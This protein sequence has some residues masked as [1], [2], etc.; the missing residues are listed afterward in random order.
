MYKVLQLKFI[1]SI[2]EIKNNLSSVLNPEY[3][4]LHNNIKLELQ[5][6]KQNWKHPIYPYYQGYSRIK[7]YGLRETTNRINSYNLIF[8]MKKDWNILDIGCNMGFISCEL[9]P[10]VNHID[11]IEVNPYLINIGKE[12]SKFL[13]IDNIDFFATKFENFNKKGYDAIL[14]FANHHTG[15]GLTSIS[16]EQ[17]FKK[18]FNILKKQGLLFFESH[19]SKYEKWASTNMALNKYFV[20]VSKKTIKKENSLM[21][22]RIFKILKKK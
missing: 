6:Q 11:A 15:D 18:I 4:Q 10:Y 1:T 7:W 17:Y 16:I 21:Q 13:K 14:S 20:E 3:N 2:L 8:Y 22:P 9:S 5:K 19:E 12:T